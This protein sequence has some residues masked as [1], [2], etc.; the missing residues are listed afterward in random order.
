MI[1]PFY[2]CYHFTCHAC[3]YRI[4]QHTNGL[5]LRPT[6]TPAFL[7]L[8]GAAVSQSALPAAATQVNAAAHQGLGC[9]DDRVNIQKK[10]NPP[11]SLTAAYTQDPPPGSSVRICK[12]QKETAQQRESRN[13]TAAAHQLFLPPCAPPISSKWH[14]ASSTYTHYLRHN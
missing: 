1:H 8:L 7:L 2:D 12:S 3:N 11:L 9:E 10:K 14:L 4:A 13:L 5:G 6:P